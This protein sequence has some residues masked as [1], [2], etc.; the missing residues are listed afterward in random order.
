MAI[1]LTQS[2][3]SFVEWLQKVT[4]N[5][6]FVPDDLTI[7]C[8]SR[9]LNVHILVYT[10]DFCWST[11]LKQF[12]MD[13][14]ELYS[15]SDI[16]LVYVGHDMYVELKHIRQPKPKQPQPATPSITLPETKINKKS[17]K[18]KVTNRG[19]KPHSKPG[20]KL[21]LPP[22]LEPRPPRRNHRRIDYLQLN[23]GLEEPELTPVKSKRHKPN[24][25]PPAMD[26]LHAG[27]QQIKNI[28]TLQEK[29][30]HNSIQTSYQT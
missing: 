29:S 3:L 10:K 27:K 13:E 25:P 26:P 21:T 30:N 9:F 4:L 2:K 23:D 18:S 24:S 15:K 7:Y 17:T 6:K 12:K 1:A 14:D 16:R 20:K 5:K 19:D 28:E 8:L 22:P 11:L